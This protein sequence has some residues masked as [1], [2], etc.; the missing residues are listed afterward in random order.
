MVSSDH[1]DMHNKGG[2]GEGIA[3]AF[4]CEKGYE[5]LDRNWR[6]YQGEIDIIA[7]KGRTIVF[8]EVKTS[9]NDKF[10]A[11]EE[12]VTRGKQRQI[13][14]IA[15]AWIQK[16]NPENCFFR[17]DV[18]TLVKQKKGF[19]IRHIEDAFTL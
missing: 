13:G 3:S 8:V 10:G 9:F 14:R 15:E 1:K 18:L 4:L 11:P 12:W 17:F 16:N 7:R 19:E 5:I 6:I 2:F